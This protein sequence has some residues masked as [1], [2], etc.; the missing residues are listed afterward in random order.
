MKELRQTV[1]LLQKRGLNVVPGAP[2]P[3]A[4]G[5]GRLIA[6]LAGTP[7]GHRWRMNLE[8]DLR[9]AGELAPGE[10]L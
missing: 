1:K 5:A 9:R 2:R 8:R 7:S 4:P 3:G 10:R 6:V